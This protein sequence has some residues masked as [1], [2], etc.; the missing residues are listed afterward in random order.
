MNSSEN[1]QSIFAKLLDKAEPIH[2]L[3]LSL[4]I[5]IGGVWAAYTFISTSE[6]EMAQKELARI[7]QDQ[8][9]VEK[10]LEEKTIK[11]EQLKERIKGANSSNIQING[12]VTELPNDKFGLI[13]NVLVQNT[14]ENNVAMSWTNSPLKVF[15]MDYKDGDKVAFRDVYTPKIWAPS[16][17]KKKFY[18]KLHLFVGVRKELSFFVELPKEGLYYITFKAETDETTAEKVDDAGHWFTSKYIY[19]E[20]TEPEKIQPIV[21][22]MGD[23]LMK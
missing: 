15:R 23:L 11:L 3:V 6:I 2:Y 17:N 16:P 5:L 4:A 7:Q 1:Q 18:E 14:G 19:V 21:V 12:Q 8:I 10:Q 22:D 9:Q 13:I 20:K